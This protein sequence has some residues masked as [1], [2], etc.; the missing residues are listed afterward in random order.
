MTWKGVERLK[1][2]E[3]WRQ[4]CDEALAAPLPSLGLGSVDDPRWPWGAMKK[5]IA[6][7]EAARAL[8]P[9][10]PYIISSR[11]PLHP[12]LEPLAAIEEP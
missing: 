4:L 9:E 6:V 8:V 10:P 11:D 2:L 7:A 3:R 12:L 1:T 5:L